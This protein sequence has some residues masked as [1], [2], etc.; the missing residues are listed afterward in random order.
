MTTKSDIKV[1]GH[2]IFY[3]FWCITLDQSTQ[4]WLKV[5]LA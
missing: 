5:F 3:Y 1:Y 2:L 4:I